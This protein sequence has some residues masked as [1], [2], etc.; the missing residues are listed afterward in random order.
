MLWAVHEPRR[1]NII[2]RAPII[3]RCLGR[4]IRNRLGET[5][6]T[7]RKLF[8]GGAGLRARLQSFP[9]MREF[10]SN[11]L[12]YGKCVSGWTGR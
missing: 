3:T 5:R 7:E 10:S 12:G 1:Q 11:R 2:F 8:H 6:P 4:L 9:V